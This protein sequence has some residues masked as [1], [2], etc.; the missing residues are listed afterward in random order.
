MTC[1]VIS[2]K[3]KTVINNTM[4]FLEILMFLVMTTLDYV[5]VSNHQEHLL[6]ELFIYK[7]IK[8]VF[9]TIAIKLFK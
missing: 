2:N 7:I 4:Y 3:N 8:K 1:N 9:N 5:Q 6:L